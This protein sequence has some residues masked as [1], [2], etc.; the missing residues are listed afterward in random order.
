MCF[1]ST[2]GR[3]LL[4]SLRRFVDTLAGLRSFLGFRSK[5]C[6]KN[7]LKNYSDDMDKGSEALSFHSL[8]L[9]TESIL[10]KD[11]RFGN[12]SL[13]VHSQKNKFRQSQT[14]NELLKRQI[15]GRFMN[16]IISGGHWAVIDSKMKCINIMKQGN[17]SYSPLVRKL[18]IGRNVLKLL[19]Q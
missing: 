7:M 4:L 8:L 16:F 14:P 10:F 9:S 12:K 19:D 3:T 1:I 13:R 17:K 2:L 11:G 6:L 5:K 15:A 18:G